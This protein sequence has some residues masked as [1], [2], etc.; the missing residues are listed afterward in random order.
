M[1]QRECLARVLSRGSVLDA[2]AKYAS[3]WLAERV[4]AMGTQLRQNEQD[5][6]R[7]SAWQGELARSLDPRPS[8]G[9]YERALFDLWR[10]STV[11]SAVVLNIIEWKS[12]ILFLALA[13]RCR[14]LGYRD[15]ED[16]LF[17]IARDEDR[18]LRVGWELLA[19]LG[20][21]D[22]AMIRQAGESLYRVELGD[23]FIEETAPRVLD[24]R[25]SAQLSLT[26]AH[27]LVEKMEAA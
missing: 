22:G 9:R 24:V 2:Y 26:I 23:Q 20:R 7:H 16:A 17:E 21:P 15:V 1:T 10:G 6:A 11:W 3:G 19:S 4:P 25:P 8:D 13:R 27:R 18:H 12:R 14:T 5:E